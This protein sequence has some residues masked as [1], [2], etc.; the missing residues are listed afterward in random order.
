MVVNCEAR[1]GVKPRI[2]EPGQCQPGLVAKDGRAALAQIGGGAGR[3]QI[4]GQVEEPPQ[5][6]HPAGPHGQVP[7]PGQEPGQGILFQVGAGRDARGGTLKGV[8]AW[9]VGPVRDGPRVLDAQQDPKRTGLATP[10]RKLDHPVGGNRHDDRRAPRRTG[11]V[12]GRGQPVDRCGVADRQLAGADLGPAGQRPRAG[13]LVLGF[14]A[15][16]A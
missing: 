8:A 9:P 15:G 16:E 2:E 12:Q 7:L 11:Q 6:V 5:A 13:R 10:G 14:A 4:A 1:S 3:D